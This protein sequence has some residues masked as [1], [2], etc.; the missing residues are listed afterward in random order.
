MEESR[1]E[2]KVSMNWVGAMSRTER[3]AIEE[4]EPHDAEPVAPTLRRAH[5]KRNRLRVQEVVGVQEEQILALCYCDAGI[6]RRCKTGVFL[7]HVT[8]SFSIPCTDL[9][10]LIIGAIVYH[11]NVDGRVGLRRT[12]STACGKYFPWR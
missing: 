7:M 1:Q 8:D 2:L 9:G 3:L 11:D 12:L 4:R 6:T 5:L 10:G